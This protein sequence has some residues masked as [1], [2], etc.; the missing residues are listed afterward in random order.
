[1]TLTWIP[2]IKKSQLRKYR[3]FG[4]ND[5]WCIVLYVYNNYYIFKRIEYTNDRTNSIKKINVNIVW[6]KDKNKYII[7]LGRLL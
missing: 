5:H 3:R 2:T 4:Y 1:M 6:I 7:N